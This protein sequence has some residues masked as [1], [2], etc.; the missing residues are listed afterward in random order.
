[1]IISKLAQQYFKITILK[2]LAIESNI[3]QQYR[4]KFKKACVVSSPTAWSFFTELFPV[5]IMSVILNPPLD[6]DKLREIAEFIKED[7]IIGIGGG[8][9][10]DCAK[11]L[12]HFSH[13]KC[14]IVPT[15]LST[16]AWL[17]PTASLK[18]EKKVFH[19]KGKID[20]VLVDPELI[21]LSPQYLNMGG[22]AD[23]LCGYNAVSDWLLSNKTI[24]ERMPNTALNIVL[25][26]CNN[27][28]N[29]IETQL[30]TDPRFAITIIPFLA[31]KFVEAFEMCY[32]LLSGRPLEGS[33]HYLYYALE[34]QYNRPLN[35]GAIIALNTLVCLKLRGNDALV[36]PELLG[37]FYDR[38]GI[39]YTLSAQ[40]I[41]PEIY[42][43]AL[44]SMHDFVKHEGL[45]YSWWNLDNPFKNCSV[46][47]IINWIS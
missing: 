11:A 1:M 43:T 17:N 23:I 2:K 42:E 3:L 26:F 14:V 13:K 18:M 25:E 12:A 27:L 19:V 24:D 15:I 28:K 34:E 47:E 29:R 41:P 37:R 4:E 36:N 31:H 16:T 30:E 44:K 39:S 22:V 21:S 45:K 6:P 38:L 35:H 7:R 10:I 32:S 40:G 5:E 8:R 46:E 20:K 9:V 33:E